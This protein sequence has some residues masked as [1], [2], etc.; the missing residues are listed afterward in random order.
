PTTSLGPQL[1]Q[2]RHYTR[3]RVCNE[4]D[5]KRLCPLVLDHIREPELASCVKEFVFRRSL[6]MKNQLEAV[7]P[8]RT[9]SNFLLVAHLKKLRDVTLVSP[10]LFFFFF[11]FF[12]FLEMKF[13]TCVTIF[14]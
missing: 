7:Q 6:H 8:S 3:I 11:S 4:D 9:S 1:Q 12:F 2:H 13:F 14:S 5:F 10:S